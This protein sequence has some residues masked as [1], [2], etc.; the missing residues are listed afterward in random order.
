MGRGAGHCSRQADMESFG[1]GHI[2]PHG[3]RRIGN[4]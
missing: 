4:R 3:T 1:G 2:V